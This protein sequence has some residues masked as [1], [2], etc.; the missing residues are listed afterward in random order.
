MKK[1]YERPQMVVETFNA[2]QSVAAGCSSAPVLKPMDVYVGQHVCKSDT[3]G[4]NVQDS[5]VTPTLDTDGNGAVT[6]FT[7]DQSCEYIF[8]TKN[9]AYDV[10]AAGR[11]MT[12]NGSWNSNVHA[13]VI[14]GVIIPS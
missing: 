5:F 6:I 3:C 13:M 7:A 11:A 14:G 2:T 12:E 1:V 10:V 8:P 4:H 9:G